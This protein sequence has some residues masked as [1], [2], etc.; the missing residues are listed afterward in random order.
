MT[1]PTYRSGVSTRP[2]RQGSARSRVFVLRVLVMSML[3]TLGARLW[4]LEI[5]DGSS[6]RKVATGN[7]TRDIVSAA[8]RGM[9]I[10]AA[11]QPL[12][13]NKTS[14]VLTVDHSVLDKQKDKGKAVLARLGP[15]V[16]QSAGELALRIRF[17]T[18]KVKQ[19]C[20]NGSPYQPIPVAS[21]VSSQQALAVLEH[22]EL[23]P[24]VTADLQ[25][26][27][28]YP[29]TTLAAHELGY[30]SQVTADE[31]AKNKKLNRSD[32]VGRSGLEEQYDAYLR[33][34]DGI[35]QLS[36]NASGHVT[37]TVANKPAVSGNSVVLS[38]DTKAQQVLE[39]ALQN[40]INRARLQGKPADTASGVVLD[41]KTGR[42]VALASLP[43]YD[44][45][46]F[47]GGISQKNYDALTN[48]NNGTPLVSRA[49]QGEYPPG[50]TFKIVSA[51]TALTNLGA[52]PDSTYACPSNLQ[53][54]NQT[55]HNF[56]SEAAGDI[57][58]HQALV[59]SCDTVFYKFGYDAWLQDGGLRNG[60]GPYA[61]AKEYFAN[62]A[63]AFGFGRPTGIDLPGETSGLVTTRELRKK[64]W[65]ENK[66]TYCRRAKTGYPEEKDPSRAAYLKQIAQENCLDGYL[67]RGGDATQFAIGQD[68]VDVSPLQLAVAYAAIA[69][70]GTVW[71]PRLAKAVINQNG[72]VTQIPSSKAGTLPISQETL[73][74]LQDAF[75]GVVSGGTSSGVFAG[76]PISTAGKTGTAET[77]SDGDVSWYASYG[78]TQDP[79]YAIVITIPHTG[80]G[81]LYA[82]PAVK[83]VWAGLYGIGRPAALPGGQEPTA[84]PCILANGNVATGK[85][86][87]K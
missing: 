16:G 27:R 11:G 39:Q 57:T 23:Y 59:I 86:C 85:G 46:V 63:K 7:T 15:I 81:A 49:F 1:G 38:L 19:P 58:I 73:H 33:G 83:E 47:T 50:S 45:S 56:D 44:P 61:P 34:Q 13:T 17:C 48:P 42:V 76:F 4:F 26:I 74:Y 69:N 72:V 87:K 10:D 35:K 14:L 75:A 53:I 3:L 54:G 8:P 66:A 31:L 64:T 71:H 6:Y 62:M 12:V 25:A 36:V 80:Q 78:P 67:Y 68:I 41:V 60:R 40:A 82:A 18:A 55:F 52:G 20:W 30:V 29:D 84:L 22:P 37:G 70:G 65:E 51:S 43:S 9:I 28:D 21:N 2:R 32:S 79:R 77:F 24:G 5:A